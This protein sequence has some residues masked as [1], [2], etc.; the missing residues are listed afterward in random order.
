[1]GV[2]KRETKGGDSKVER[3][4]GFEDKA[5]HCRGDSN[6]MGKMRLRGDSNG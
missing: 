6:L 3:S 5:K 4:N 1:M 2:S